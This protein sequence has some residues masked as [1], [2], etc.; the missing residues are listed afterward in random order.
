MLTVSVRRILCLN[1][2]ALMTFVCD[3]QHSHACVCFSHNAY[4][5][6]LPGAIATRERLIPSV[7]PDGQF[8]QRPR[9][10]LGY[11]KNVYSP[12]RYGIDLLPTLALHLSFNQKLEQ[13]LQGG[14]KKLK[15]SSI[16]QRFCFCESSHCSRYAL[17][18]ELSHQRVW[19]VHRAWPPVST[20]PCRNVVWPSN[21]RDQM[22]AR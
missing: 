18:T 15:V 17:C 12:S 19:A 1:E 22:A 8:Q 4:R 20:V 16:L 10:T 21:L 5:S 9:T 2:S 6:L 7:K 3:V 11:P 14:C 13:Q